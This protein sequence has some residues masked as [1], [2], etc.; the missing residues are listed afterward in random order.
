MEI[1]LNTNEFGYKPFLK[2]PI[3]TIVVGL[4]NFCH[5]QFYCVTQKQLPA[6]I[7]ELEQNQKKL[8][9]SINLFAS[10]KQIIK[11]DKILDQLL[12]LEIDT[13]IVSD[14]GVLNLFKKRNLQNKVTLDLQTYVTN[15]Y[16]ARSLLNFGVKKVVLSKEITLNDIKE[17]SN[18]NSEHIE[19][20]CQGYYPITYSKRPILSCYYKN[21]RLKKNKNIHYIKEESRNSKYILIE[22]NNLLTVY[23]NTQ[24]SLFSYLDILYK[25]NITKLRIDTN[26]MSIEEIDSYIYFYTK[27]IKFI[28]ENNFNEY[29]K[30]KKE[31][32]NKFIY[33]TPFLHTESFLLKEGK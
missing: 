2:Y 3:E 4:K 18:Y 14:L 27:A 11:L 25:N 16:S 31:F 6:L 20:L 22:Q 15:K 26:F 33:E 21:F 5:N 28:K 7:K 9:L 13:F 30:L 10:E 12:N 19:I 8:C 1:L 17:I 24:Y 32:N 23:N 29:E